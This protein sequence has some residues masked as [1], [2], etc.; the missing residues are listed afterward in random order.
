MNKPEFSQDQRPPFIQQQNSIDTPPATKNV[1]SL[2]FLATPCR[3]A[4]LAHTLRSPKGK[5]QQTT[6]THSSSFL[7]FKGFMAWRWAQHRNPLQGER[8]RRSD[9]HSHQ[10]YSSPFPF[11]FLG[12]WVMGLFT[13]RIRRRVGTGKGG[14]MKL[15]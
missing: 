12:V 5:N 2:L 13:R 9:C 7:Y 3:S 10:L 6:S 4:W 1:I 15:S 11:H 8:E 14:V